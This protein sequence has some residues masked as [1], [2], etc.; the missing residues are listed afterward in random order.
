MLECENLHKRLTDLSNRLDNLQ[1]SETELRNRIKDTTTALSTVKLPHITL[2][3]S[4]ATDAVNEY[5]NHERRKYNLIIYGIPESAGST[6][7]C[8][9]NDNIY[10]SDLV[11]S[12]FKMDTIEITKCIRLGK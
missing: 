6:E 9:Q 1:S 2:A 4:S 3:S 12:E 10:I 11:H 8:K 5:L 7:E